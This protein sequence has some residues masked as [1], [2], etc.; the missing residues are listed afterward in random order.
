MSINE[1]HLNDLYSTILKLNTVEECKAFL[2]DLCTHKEI[3]QM[4]Q[5]ITAAKCLLA[6]E[7]YE[8]VI[9]KTDIS[10]ATLSK[11]SKAIKY[12]K[13]YKSVLTNEN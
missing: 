6:G 10:S 2:E 1:V 13:G 3:E 7:T 9:K 8:S 5:R 12:G 11:V 4:A